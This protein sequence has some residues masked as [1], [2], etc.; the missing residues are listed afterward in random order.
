MSG[1]SVIPR[2]AFPAP[3][4]GELVLPVPVFVE[5]VLPVPVFVELVPP[6]PA[7]SHRVVAAGE[8]VAWVP[9]RF[10]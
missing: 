3:S 7:I 2:E 8:E 4:F 1:S 10:R 9:Q 5:P 6:E